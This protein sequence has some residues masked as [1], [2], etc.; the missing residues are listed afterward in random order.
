[1]LEL[2]PP[3]YTLALPLFAN[4]PQHVLPQA[5]CQGHNPGRVFVDQQDAPRTALIG[6]TVG[7]FLLAGESAPEQLPSLHQILHESLLPAAQAAGETGFILLPAD[8]SWKPH[9]PTLLPGCEVLEIYRRPFAFD[10]AQFAK[11]API[12]IPDGFQL[13]PVDAG[14]AERVGILG[15]WATVEDFLAHGLG[16]ALVAGEEIASVCTS[17]FAS[18]T[19]VE[20]DIHTAEKYQRRGFATLTARAFIAACLERG[21]HPNWECFWENAPSIALAERVGFRALPDYPVYYWEI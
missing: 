1:M 16:V 21:L 14:L 13:L 17:V 18:R 15:S 20:L 10:A 3:E 8:E 2:A 5:I 9:L 12:Q 7:Y 6:T 19:R 11:H 4:F